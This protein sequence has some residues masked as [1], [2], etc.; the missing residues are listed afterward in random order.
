MSWYQD[1]A[2]WKRLQ[3]RAMVRNFAWEQS[4]QQYLGFYDSVLGVI[5]PDERLP[6]PDR[7]GSAVDQAVFP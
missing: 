4:A 1:S 5:T 7:T 3:R 2:A 6:E